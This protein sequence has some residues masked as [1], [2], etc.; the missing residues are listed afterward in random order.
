MARNLTTPVYSGSLK[1]DKITGIRHDKGQRAT[2]IQN[3]VKP[4]TSF[5]PATRSM[6]TV[7]NITSDG[8]KK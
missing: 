8:L 3:L 5:K 7:A 2:P 6:K 1:L 4:D